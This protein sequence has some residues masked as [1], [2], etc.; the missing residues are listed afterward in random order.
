[1][2]PDPTKRYTW[3]EYRRWEGDD[4]WELIDGQPFLM[5]GASV[6]H[7]AVVGEIFYQLRRHFEGAPCRAFT[8]PLEVKFSERDGA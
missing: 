2:K 8:A 3:D 7:Q 4:R 1:M 5:A 6:L